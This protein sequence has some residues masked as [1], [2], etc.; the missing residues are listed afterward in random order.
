MD[1]YTRHWR[2][3]RSF[4]NRS[5]VL[6]QTNRRETTVT[7]SV[8]ENE[9]ES[10]DRAIENAPMTARGNTIVRF[11]RNAVPHGRMVEAV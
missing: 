4:A 10:Q 2:I 9:I 6:A 3:P 7:R 11:F 8:D 5:I 1:S